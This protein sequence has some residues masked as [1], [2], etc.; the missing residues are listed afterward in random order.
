MQGGLGASSIRPRGFVT[1]HQL[2]SV[3]GRITGTLPL[4]VLSLGL[5]VSSSVHVHVMF[6]LERLCRRILALKKCPVLF[7][8]LVLNDNEKGPYRP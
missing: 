4:L 2:E 7:M 5:N 8:I 1:L 3:Q 6:L